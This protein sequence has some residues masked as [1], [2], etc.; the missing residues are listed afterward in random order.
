MRAG[1][2]DLVAEPVA[3]CQ[4]VAESTGQFAPDLRHV[5]THIGIELDRRLDQLRLHVLRI[6]RPLD[7]PRG[8]RDQVLRLGVEDLELQLDTKCRS[9]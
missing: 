3:G 9:R 2:R 5:L 7:D 8:S 6:T 1:R 4:Q